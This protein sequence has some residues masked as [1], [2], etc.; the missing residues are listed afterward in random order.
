VFSFFRKR[1]VSNLDEKAIVDAIRGAESL[2]RAE[3]RVH[4]A[5]K[6]GKIGALESAK[7]IFEKL[8]M[9]RTEMRNGVLIFVCLKERK[10]A[11]IGDVGIHQFVSDTF[12][13]DIKTEMQE[14]MRQGKHTEAIC[15]GINRAGEKLQLHFPAGNQNPNELSNEISRG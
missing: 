3:I 14:L 13:D 7:K 11:I 8:G 9:H 6:T 5:D 1:A 15:H 2:S 10:F 4:L 12:W